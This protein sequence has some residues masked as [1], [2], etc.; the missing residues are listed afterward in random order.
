VTELQALRGEGIRLD[1]HDRPA[2]LDVAA[3][4]GTASAASCISE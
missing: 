3:L 4:L 1:D 2:I